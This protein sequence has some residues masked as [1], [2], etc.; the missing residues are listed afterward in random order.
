MLGRAGDRMRESQRVHGNDKWKSNRRMDW[1]ADYFV[2]ETPHHSPIS[3]PEN[4][5]R[6]PPRR[7]ERGED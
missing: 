7:P 1:P 6:I 5:A 4:G 3:D 2:V